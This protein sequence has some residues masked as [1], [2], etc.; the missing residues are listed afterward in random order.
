MFLDFLNSYL[1]P[2]VGRVAIEDVLSD[3]M[4]LCDSIF[5][6]TVLGP[7]LWN[8]FFHDVVGPASFAGEEVALFA[9]DLTSFKAF[10]IDKPNNEIEEEM[11][12]TRSE[13]HR[14]G[15]RNRVT[16]DS[17]K[18][19][20]NILHPLHGQGE[21][22]KLLGCPIDVK[23][24]MSEAVDLI[25]ARARPKIKA[26]LRSRAFYSLVDL[27]VQFKTHIW[28][29]I[30]YSHGCVLHA[31]DTALA[32]IDHL[33]SAFVRE[34]HVT[35]EF[36]FLVHN[37]APLEL[38]RDIGILGFLHK[39]VLGECHPAIM[40]LLPF[41]SQ[42]YAWRHPK[43]LETYLE[44]CVVRPVLYWRSLFGL[45]HVYNRLPD[46][47][48]ASPSVKVFQARLTEG[49]KKRC[50]SGDPLWRRAFRDCAQLWDSLPHL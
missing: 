2:R 19:H 47:V 42:N 34:L 39:R 49:A 45:I 35:E 25:V 50:S 32:K 21:S 30:E 40:N 8:T 33:Q 46:Y 12:A 3:V 41:S 20:I 28:G 17:G 7:A 38:R 27:I 5:Q 4:T 1:E 24:T 23:L 36:V 44:S 48:I 16:F 14:W 6:G 18:E 10:P 11:R 22:F 43:Q 13:V 29:I 37:F 31:S 9:D 26:L 15:E